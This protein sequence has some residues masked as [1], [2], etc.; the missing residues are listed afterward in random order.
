VLAECKS[1]E[2]SVTLNKALQESELAQKKLRAELQNAL[3]AEKHVRK[4]HSHL[5]QS[6]EQVKLAS[7][8]QL[9]QLLAAQAEEMQQKGAAM[10]DFRSQLDQLRERL[11]QTDEELSRESLSKRELQEMHQA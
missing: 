1:V 4:L 10:A 2:D 9:K 7:A 5:E 8:E 11:R 6:H 3:D